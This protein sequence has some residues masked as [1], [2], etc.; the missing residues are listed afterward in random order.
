M[1]GAGLVGLDLCGGGIGPSPFVPFVPFDL[2][3]GLGVSK[4]IGT[5]AGGGGGEV[6]AIYGGLCAAGASLSI[7]IRSGSA[8]L[9]ESVESL[10]SSGGR[11]RGCVLRS[12]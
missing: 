6:G 1:V 7:S 3:G 11:L 12:Y 9:F 2:G 4:A 5:F 8:I 10:R